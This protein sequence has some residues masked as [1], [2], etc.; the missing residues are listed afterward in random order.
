MVFIGWR[1]PLSTLGDEFRNVWTTF[2]R[3]FNRLEKKQD[4]L[5]ELHENLSI[6]MGLVVQKRKEVKGDSLEN[7]LTALWKDLE[8]ISKQLKS[9]EQELNRI[10]DAEFKARLVVVTKNIK[11][12]KDNIYLTANLLKQFEEETEAKG[13][14]LTRREFLKR[15]GNITKKSLA[16]MLIANTGMTAVIYKALLHF[17]EDL[18]LRKTN[19]LAVLISYKTTHW[20]DA[21]L[22]PPAKLL[23]PAY[24]ARIEIAFGQKVNIVKRGATKDDLIAVLKDK[25]IQNI[26]IYGHGSWDS[27]LATDGNVTAK[28]LEYGEKGNDLSFLGDRKNGLFVRHTCGTYRLDYSKQNT[29]PSLKYDEH[30]VAALIAEAKEIQ[31]MLKKIRATNQ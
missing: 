3:N 2:I 5:K 15:A 7:V 11:H 1:R 28:D 6:L 13:E 17:A 24:I 8:S 25:T 10:N 31:Q 22:K 4:Q 9:I 20:W 30:A 29:M 21:T 14:K 19:G 12:T 18:P 27:W 26:V 23:I 16:A